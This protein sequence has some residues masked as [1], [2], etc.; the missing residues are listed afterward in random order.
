MMPVADADIDLNLLRVL[1]ALLENGSVAGAAKVLHVSP[2]AVSRSLARL[3]L[4]V[5]DPLFVRAGRSM[6]PTDVAIGLR[7]PARR[8]LDAAV[9]VLKPSLSADPGVIERRFVICADDAVVA[10]LALP[11]ITRLRERAPGVD[12]S[13]VS[14]VNDVIGG[15]RAATLDLRID[16]H[17]DAHHDVVSEVILTDRF[18][19]AVRDGHPLLS[20]RMTPR[21]Y[22]AARHVTVSPKGKRRGPI[23]SALEEL[24]LEREHVTTITSFVVA[25]HLVAA[26]DLVGSLPSSVVSVMARTLPI[27]A[28]EI[29]LTVPTFD[30]NLV[31]HV[32]DDLDAAHLWLRQ[33]ILEAFGE[34]QLKSGRLG[35]TSRP[36]PTK[37]GER[38]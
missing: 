14:D 5:G 19:A 9:A 21:R 1:D 17:V 24:G 34:L 29:P 11:L 13:F 15:F 36:N 23:D 18:V 35:P 25:A 32:R 16:A 12:I 2:P 26:T 7:E 20:G 31:W 27:R 38:K 10:A 4:V 37:R 3:R 30:L 33:Q 28:L 8:A 22:A 6:V